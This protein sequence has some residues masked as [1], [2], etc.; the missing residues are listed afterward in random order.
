MI[1]G[2]IAK[3]TLLLIIKFVAGAN[4]YLLETLRRLKL[5]TGRRSANP[6]LTLSGL[7]KGESTATLADS[8]VSA[9]QVGRESHSIDRK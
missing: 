7:P 6:P 1:L 5:L 3:L 2:T 4:L 9:T 8:F